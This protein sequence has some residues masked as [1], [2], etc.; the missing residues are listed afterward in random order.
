MRCMNIKIYKEKEKVN[1]NFIILLTFQNVLVAY[2]L[3][4]YN[5]SVL[6]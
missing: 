1:Y 3:Y 2:K 5:M 4:N 6:Y